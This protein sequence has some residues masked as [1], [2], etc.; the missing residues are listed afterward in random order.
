ITRHSMICPIIDVN[1]SHL[2]PPHASIVDIFTLNHI[3]SDTVCLI[4]STGHL[5]G[6]DNVLKHWT[7]LFHK[8]D[9]VSDFALPPELTSSGPLS[10]LTKSYCTT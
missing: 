6:F 1:I 7:C 10:T 2:L 3:N 4:T 8:H 5:Y 9:F